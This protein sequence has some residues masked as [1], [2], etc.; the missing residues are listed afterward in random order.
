M[1]SFKYSLYFFSS[2]LDHFIHNDANLPHVD[3]TRKARAFSDE[4][5]GRLDDFF[6]LFCEDK[7]A[8]QN[9]TY[10]ESWDY[11]T[12]RE[13]MESIKRHTNF[14]ILLSNLKGQMKEDS[15]TDSEVG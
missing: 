4:Y 9:M 6:K 2:N 11:I 15:T 10:K 14:N 5:N 8:L 7:D 13:S 1:S 12:N 3:K